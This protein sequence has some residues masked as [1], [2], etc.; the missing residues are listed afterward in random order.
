MER[1]QLRM[2]ENR[3]FTR[4]FGPNRDDVTGA[5]RKLHNRALHNL[6]SFPNIIRHIKSR[7]TRWEGYVTRIGEERKL[8]KVMVGKPEG[9]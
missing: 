5:W 3:V 1:I 8:Y 6:C 4:I 9:K 2:C 7:R